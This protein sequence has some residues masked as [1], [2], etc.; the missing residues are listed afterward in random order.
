MLLRVLLWPAYA[1]HQLMHWEG[2]SNCERATSTDNAK[3]S[4]LDDEDQRILREL[5]WYTAAQQ[6]TERVQP[7]HRQYA[8]GK[9][10]CTPQISY[11][12]VKL[13][14]ARQEKKYITVGR[15]MKTFLWGTSIV[16]QKVNG[17]LRCKNNTWWKI[18]PVQR[19]SVRPKLQQNLI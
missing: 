11:R 19:L 18:T 14:M 12:V 10:N 1:I 8:L 15:S 9:I 5:S 2:E 17:T 7:W 3:W 4:S 13:S 6:T 16:G